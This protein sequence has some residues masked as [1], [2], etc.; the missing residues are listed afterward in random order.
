MRNKIVFI[1]FILITIALGFF[2]DSLFVNINYQIGFLYYKQDIN[3]VTSNFSFLKSLS[4][5]QLYYGKWL[6]TIAFT[7]LYYILT[8]AT[9]YFSFGNKNIL[10]WATISYLILIIVSAMAYSIGQI[11]SYPQTGYKFARIF[12]GLLQSPIVLMLLFPLFQL[13]SK[14][15]PNS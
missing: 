11:T 14:N 6:L 8:M 13:S 9:I 15:N 7:L 12:M 1:L 5:N 2:R 4:F 3:Y 10:R